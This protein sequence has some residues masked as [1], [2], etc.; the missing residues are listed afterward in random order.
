[1]QIEKLHK[2]V[3]TRLINIYCN[4]KNINLLKELNKYMNVTKLYFLFSNVKMLQIMK[5][6]VLNLKEN[7]RQL[8]TRKALYKMNTTN[9]FSNSLIYVNLKELLLDIASEIC[10]LFVQLKLIFIF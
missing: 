5:L 2:V 6:C 9:T 1:M 8:T 7:H 3:V 10:A 4:K